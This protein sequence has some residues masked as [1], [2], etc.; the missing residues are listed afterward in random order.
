MA[1]FFTLTGN[2][3]L[4]HTGGVHT[5]LD[6]LLNFQEIYEPHDHWFETDYDGNVTLQVTTTNGCTHRSC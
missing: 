1:F 4:V 2:Y 3:S 5:G 6:S